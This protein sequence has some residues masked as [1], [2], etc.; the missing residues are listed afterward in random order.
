[1]WSQALI[2]KPPDWG[3]HIRITGFSFLPLASTYQPPDDLKDFLEAG[4]PP[5]YIGFG[6]IVVAKP[7]ELTELI[8]KAV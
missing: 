5:V 3:E 7:N 8:F 2:A 1:M 4:P 6:S